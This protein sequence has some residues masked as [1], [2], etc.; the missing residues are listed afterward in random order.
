MGALKVLWPRP[1]SAPAIDTIPVRSRLDVRTFRV[2]Y[3][4]PALLLIATVLQAQS[5]RR[6]PGYRVGVAA[7][8]AS[9]G[10]SCGD[11]ADTKARFGPSAS[12]SIGRTLSPKLGFGLE[13]SGWWKGVNDAVDHQGYL[14]AT[15]MYF[16]GRTGVFVTGSVGLARFAS[17][18]GRGDDRTSTLAAAGRLGV[19]YDLPLGREVS[20]APF[21]S[22]FRSIPAGLKINGN[23][24]GTKLSQHLLQVGVGL[25]WNFS[26]AISFP[27]PTGESLQ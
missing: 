7:A 26:G 1:R 9:A 17:V 3:P 4:I 14:L 16:P 23:P 5:A 6:I 11:C 18:V 15:G 25:L 20:V 8:G 27:A 12:V 24:T 2:L 22:Y 13:V 21:A 10:L 19:G